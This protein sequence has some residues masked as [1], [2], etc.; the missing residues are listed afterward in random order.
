MQI[1]FRQIPSVVL[2]WVLPDEKYRLKLWVRISLH[3]GV[4]DHYVIKFVSDLQQVDGFLRYSVSSTNKTDSHDIAEI[5][6]KV[7][8]NTI[9]LT[10]N[11]SFEPLICI[12]ECL[13]ICG[14]TT[15]PMGCFFC[16]SDVIAQVC[17]SNL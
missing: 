17:C 13:G 5:L 15:F 3:R 4:L 11:P 10:P 7:A 12:G 6:L 14:N 9:T 8:L 2:A 1:L 16:F